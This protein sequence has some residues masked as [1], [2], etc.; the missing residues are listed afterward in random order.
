MSHSEWQT[1][2][3]KVGQRIPAP[4][5]LVVALVLIQLSSGL[6]KTIMNSENTL[7]L[8]FLRLVIG[9]ILLWSVIRPAV[10]QF[11]K[12]QWVHVSILGIVYAF[13]NVTAYK[14]LTHLPLGLVATIGFLGPIAVSVAGARRALD[15]AW[16]VLGFA[17]VFLLAPATG[18]TEYSWGSLAYGL[19]YAAA[20]GAFILASARAGRSLRG[21]DGFVV[22][23]VI[24][25]VL[26]L[27][28]G[29]EHVPHFSSSSTLIVMTLLVSVM[30]TVAF[31][32]EYIT[33]KR[34]EPRVF[35]VLL[36]LEPALASII[37][38]ILLHEVLS[39]SSWLAIAVVTAAAIGA[40]LFRDSR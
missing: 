36:S 35:G 21:L 22:A 32:L 40:T 25:A 2:A 15:F 37:G 23:T 1:A 9:G 4:L 33:L 12:E 19:A 17:G 13:F 27:P 34:I 20:W 29:Y 6:A 7:G 18:D 28:V 38:I 14:A 11:T 39:I 10:A 3:A 8:A 31:G 16:P 5:I 30:I 24:A 26:L